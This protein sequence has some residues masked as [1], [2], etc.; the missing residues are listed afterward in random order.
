[1]TNQIIFEPHMMTEIDSELLTAVEI[2]NSRFSEAIG[3]INYL[4]SI[5]SRETRIRIASS[6]NLLEVDRNFIKICRANGYLIIYNLV[7]STMYEAVKGLYQHLEI[8]VNSIDS[9]IDKLKMLVFRGIRNS[10]D[11]NLNEFRNNM[12]VDFRTSI[13]QICFHSSQVKKMFSGN[14]DAKKIRSFSE[15]HGIN[16]NLIEESNNGGVLLSI[17]DTRNDLAHGAVSFTSKGNISVEQLCKLC[18]EVGYYL[19][20]VI[21][22]IDDFLKNQQYH[23][24]DPIQ[25]AV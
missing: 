12:N 15:E 8:R 6:P 22:S 3:Y 4:K 17:K 9:L 7:E 23:K 20:S 14:L 2:F 1:M 5:D 11:K 10:T 25:Q 13:F 19:R 24:L 21:T 18:T 16:L